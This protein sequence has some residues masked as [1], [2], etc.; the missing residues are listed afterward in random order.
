MSSQ[1]ADTMTAAA[2]RAFQWLLLL[3]AI[4]LLWPS[5]TRV[6]YVAPSAQHVAGLLAHVE[7]M[8]ADLSSMHRL[9]K[10]AELAP[11]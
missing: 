5:R 7:H 11:A 2:A 10:E 9:L 8:L 6:Q 1:A 3:Q 4:G